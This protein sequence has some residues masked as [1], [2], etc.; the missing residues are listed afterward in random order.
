ME[1]VKQCNFGDCSVGIAEELFVGYTVEMASDG[2]FNVSDIMKI[3]S[4]V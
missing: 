2:V 1:F 3:G 4:G